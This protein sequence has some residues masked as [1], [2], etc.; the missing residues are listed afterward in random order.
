M[1]NSASPP[2][3]LLLELVFVYGLVAID[4]AV[5]TL[6]SSPYSNYHFAFSLPLP[7]RSFI[8]IA[9]VLITLAT[10]WLYLTPRERFL[11]RVALV[12]VISGGTANTL[13]RV[14]RGFVTDIIQITQASINLADVYI[15]V[16]VI[17]LLVSAFFRS[18]ENY[19]S[20]TN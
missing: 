6:A 18:K 3:H 10:I 2:R 7:P 8:S 5:K 13:E 9:L 19:P 1:K 16:G 4:L 11:R 15:A 20:N 17:A 14:C 12:L